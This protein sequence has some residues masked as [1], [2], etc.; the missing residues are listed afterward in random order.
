MALFLGVFQLILACSSAQQLAQPS[1]SKPPSAPVVEAP[2]VEKQVQLDNPMTEAVLK[3]DT[4]PPPVFKIDTLITAYYGPCF[5]K[6]QVYTISITNDGLVYWHGY[7]NTSKPGTYLT[8]LTVSQKEQ[9]EAWLME[10]SIQLLTE[11]YPQRAD[12][13]SD[14]PIRQYRL[15]MNGQIKRIE[16]NHSPPP[17]ISQLE[18]N[19]ENWLSQVEWRRIDD[20]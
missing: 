15:K 5:G 13:I 10:P 14:F 16:I 19:L 4:V 3:K 17:M 1:S 20:K 18:L 6:C 11:T 2:M 9:L 12:Y 8:K 7:K